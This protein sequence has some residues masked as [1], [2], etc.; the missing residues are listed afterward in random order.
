LTEDNNNSDNVYI[1]YLSFLY[2]E[3]DYSYMSIASIINN[4]GNSSR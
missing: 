4:G 3:Q 1:L 2:E